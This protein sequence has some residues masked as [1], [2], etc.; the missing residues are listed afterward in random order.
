M[1]L[2]TAAVKS[3]RSFCPRDRFSTRAFILAAGIVQIGLSGKA[4]RRPHAD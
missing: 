3:E 4:R 1:N 2:K